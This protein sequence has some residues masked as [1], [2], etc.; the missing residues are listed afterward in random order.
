MTTLLYELFSLPSGFV[1][2]HWDAALKVLLHENNSVLLRRK[3]EGRGRIAA[4]LDPG[5][6][7]H[8]PES[9]TSRLHGLRRPADPWEPPEWRER[10][11]ESVGFMRLQ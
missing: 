4:P 5:S 2:R 3:S 7:S 1:T 6:R 11:S 9:A 10:P 8:N